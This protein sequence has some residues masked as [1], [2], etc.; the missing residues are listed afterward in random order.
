[1]CNA[2]SEGVGTVRELA[3][4]LRIRNDAVSFHT[5]TTKTNPNETAVTV[6]LIRNNQHQ[7]LWSPTNRLRIKFLLL[8]FLNLVHIP[9]M[10]ERFGKPDRVRIKCGA[11][12]TL[13]VHS[14]RLPPKDGN[15]VLCY[16]TVGSHSVA[17]HTGL[18]IT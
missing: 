8:L 7:R 9:D 4:L 17:R 6:E 10:N 12:W 15:P 5:I 11:K 1:M 2:T 14:A 3:I 13:A 16:L 18:I